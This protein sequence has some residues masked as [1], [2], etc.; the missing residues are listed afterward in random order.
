MRVCDVPL[1]VRIGVQIVQF[2]LGRTDIPKSAIG[3]TGQLGPSEVIEA[4]ER[5]RINQ[6]IR[7]DSVAVEKRRE[8]TSSKVAGKR[9]F[10]QIENR[11]DQVNLLHG[12][13]HA[14][15]GSFPGRRLDDQRDVKGIV[16]GQ[17]TVRA[18]AVIAQSLTVGRD[19]HN[20]GLIVELV[21]LEVSNQAADDVVDRHDGVVV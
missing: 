11:R 12:D 17:Q 1:L 15:A 13:L 16:V 14:T 19:E 4:V 8:R 18:F 9:R 10:R 2:F 20:R 5:F 3:Q 7:N 21:R 6:L